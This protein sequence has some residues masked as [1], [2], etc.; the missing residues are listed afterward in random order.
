MLDLRVTKLFYDGRAFPLAYRW[1]AVLLQDSVGY[2]VVGAVAIVLGLY[3]VNIVVK[4]QLLGVDGRTVCYILLV[5][6]LGA[7]VTVN[8][9]LKDHFGRAR[10]RHVTEFGGKREFTPAFALSNACSTNCSFASGDAAGAFFGFALVFAL[11][12]RRALLWPAVAFG[13]LVSFA[14]V[15]SGA[16]FLSD[17]VVSF[18][19]MWIT[20]DAMHFYLLAPARAV[21]VPAAVAAEAVPT[22]PAEELAALSTPAALG[23]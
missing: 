13:S 6:I 15:A 5:L 12:R 18:F 2:F 8:F 14:R 20:A 10:P 4:R 7:G 21:V 3:L 16:H 9:V 1:W 19:V 22:L 17:V 11:G 23:D